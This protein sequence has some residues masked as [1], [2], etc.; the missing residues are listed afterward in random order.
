MAYLFGIS[1]DEM[2]MRRI[3]TILAKSLFTL[4]SNNN[5]LLLT[6]LK[7]LVVK[8]GVLY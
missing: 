4:W 6:W 8:I 1:Y 3:M 7:K 2:M 5:I